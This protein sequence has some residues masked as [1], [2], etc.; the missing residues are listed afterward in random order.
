MLPKVLVER[1]EIHVSHLEL[2]TRRPGRPAHGAPSLVSDVR[3]ACCVH[4]HLGEHGFPSHLALNEGSLDRG[5]IQDR[6][7]GE[8]V[9]E[10][11][12]ASL[13]QHLDQHDLELLGVDDDAGH[14][15]TRPT[16]AGRAASDHPVNYFPGQAMDDW[17]TVTI[18]EAIPDVRH[19]PGGGYPAQGAIPLNQHGVGPGPRGCD[20]CGASRNPAPSNEHINGVQDLNL[21]GRFTDQHGRPSYGR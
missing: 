5:T 3:L 18:E 11:S 13:L 8:R 9:G 20:R 15:T 17:A 19:E 4:N 14:L 16:L 1:L 7:R 21:S 2:K 6:P 12:D 10:H